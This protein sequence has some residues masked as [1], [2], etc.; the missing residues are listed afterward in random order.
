MFIPVQKLYLRNVKIHT[1]ISFNLGCYISSFDL[2]NDDVLCWDLLFYYYD[3]SVKYI[4]HSYEPFI[5]Y[6]FNL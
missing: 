3:V 5:I 2:H 4:I 6:I 1:I